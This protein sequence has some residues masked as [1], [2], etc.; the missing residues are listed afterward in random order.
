MGS[1][2]TK[3]VGKEMLSGSRLSGG[4]GYAVYIRLLGIPL[5]SVSPAKGIIGFRRSNSEPKSRFIPE[6][7]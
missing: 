2:G 3:G 7:A 1:G 6:K 5:A 4:K